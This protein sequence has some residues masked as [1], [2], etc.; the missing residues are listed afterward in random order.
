[1]QKK[2][3][4]RIYTNFI[5]LFLKRE[6]KKKQLAIKQISLVIQAC[7]HFYFLRIYIDMIFFSPKFYLYFPSLSIFIY[8]S[9][10][11]YPSTIFYSF[12]TDKILMHYFTNLCSSPGY[13]HTP[14]LPPPLS[15]VINCFN[16]RQF[17]LFPRIF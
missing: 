12:L 2:Q 1:M 13:N 7:I 3:L 16:I 17:I 9:S 10:L 11:A 4:L 8:V 15:L 14:S 6:N 5:V